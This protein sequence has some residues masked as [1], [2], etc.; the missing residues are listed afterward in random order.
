M[1]IEKKIITLRSQI[2]VLFFN[3]GKWLAGFSSKIFLSFW[4]ETLFRISDF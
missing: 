4:P 1:G 3:D 2:L